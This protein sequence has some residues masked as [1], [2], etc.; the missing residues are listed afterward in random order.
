MAEELISNTRRSCDGEPLRL[1]S[2]SSC[3]TRFSTSSECSR[4]SVMASTAPESSM[5]Q[6]TWEAD[7][8]G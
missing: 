4:V 3:S 5:I 6:R 1:G 8:D 7:E 2:P